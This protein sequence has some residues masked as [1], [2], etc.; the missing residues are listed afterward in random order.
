MLKKKKKK[1]QKWVHRYFELNITTQCFENKNPEVR[2]LNT[3]NP[4]VD[5]KYGQP[6]SE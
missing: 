4:V 2:K 1:I 3:S 6:R 5:M